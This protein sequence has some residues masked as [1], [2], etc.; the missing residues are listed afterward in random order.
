MGQLGSFPSETH[1]FLH[2][3]S[4]VTTGVCITAYTYVLYALHG[5]IFLFSL[6]SPHLHQQACI[7][8]RKSLSFVECEFREA[9]RLNS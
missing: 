8:L 1:G 4:L 3:A 6:F 7:I 9:F 2:R 5:Q